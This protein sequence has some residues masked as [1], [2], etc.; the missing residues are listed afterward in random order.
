MNWK[1]AWIT[2]QGQ[3]HG[4]QVSTLPNYKVPNLNIQI[5]LTFVHFRYPSNFK[6]ASI[7]NWFKSKSLCGPSKCS[8]IT[9]RNLVWWFTRLP[10]VTCHSTA[11]LCCQICNIIPFIFICL[12]FGS[13]IKDGETCQ[14]TI[15][16][17]HFWVYILLVFPIITSCS[18]PTNWTCGYGC[19]Q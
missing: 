19:H 4:N 13:Q 7:S 18:I 12:H 2:I 15:L 6:K 14:E 8:A 16:E 9:Q 3:Y 5:K 17:I 11:T 1:F 10:E